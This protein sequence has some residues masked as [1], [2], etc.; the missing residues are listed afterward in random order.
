MIARYEP[1]AV[2]PGTEAETVLLAHHRD[3][4]GV[5]VIANDTALMPLMRDKRFAALRLNGL[6]LPYIPSYSWDRR[7]K[8]V[9]E[10][11]FPLVVKPMRDTSGSRGLH[12]VTT[13]R[14]LDGLAATLACS[15]VQAE[16]MPDV[17]PYIG[18][19]DREYTVGVVTGTDGSLF[20]SV[21]MR[22]ELTGFSLHTAGEHE[23]RRVAVSTGFSQG[24]FVR[25]ELV[26]GF[27]EDLAARLGSRGPL[28]IQLRVHDGKPHVFEI[29]PRFSFSTGM[30][31][32]A[33]FGEADMLLRHWLDGWKPDG[34][35][36]YRTGVAAIRAFTHILVD[37]QDLLS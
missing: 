12:L 21:A 28:N 34:P 13:G 26:Q 22:R 29:H 20:G 9:A 14:E 6:G 30:R 25:D 33:G 37:E 16:K 8:A 11:G 10:F 17:Q 36:G 7:D 18:D 4:L 3:A 15:G 24:H 19:C 27:C 5:P 31:A 35:V 1:A 23:G 32:A 2:I